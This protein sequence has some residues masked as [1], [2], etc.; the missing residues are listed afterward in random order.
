M[1]KIL[2][3]CLFIILVGSISA[4]ADENIEIGTFNIRFFPCN[5]DDEL[6]K[7]YD[8]NLR[9]PANG[10]ATDTVMLFEMLKD[11]DIEILGVEEI[12]DPPLFGAMA[13]RHMGEHYEFAYAPS[14]GWQKVGFLYNSDKVKLL[15]EPTIYNEVALGKV[16]R[17]RPAFHGYF[18]AIPDGFDF[19]VI[20]LH[21]KASPRGYDVRKEQWIELK[22]ILTALPNDDRKDADV[23]V[24][25]DFNNVSSDRYNEF[26][27][28]LDRLHYFWIGAE[29]D[30]LISS[31]W[32]PDYSKPEIKGSIIDQIIISSDAKIEYIENSTRV[33][34]L[35]SEGR[36]TI[37]GDFP[38]YY[39][40]ISDHCPVY[41][42]FRA[43][44]DDD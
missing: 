39:L 3:F 28:L 41:S 11:L 1:Y 23:V 13:K 24:V 29:N 15:G 44:P 35:C 10:V 31:Y 30:R 17:L 18:K 16:D 2:L 38:K 33:G 22:K 25:G 36:E 40:E 20:V 14:N 8:I 6:M 19:H 27:P 37:T 34:G 26:L 5:Q 9:Y 12:V 21:L 32:R 43:F 4:Q 7:K 42:S